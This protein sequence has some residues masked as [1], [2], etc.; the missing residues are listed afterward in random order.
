MRKRESFK[1]KD[2]QP[3]SRGHFQG[4]KKRKKGVFCCWRRP[5]C[6]RSSANTTVIWLMCSLKWWS[7]VKTPC[8]A[9]LKQQELWQSRDLRLQ[10]II[11]RQD[12]LLQMVHL[13]ELLFDWCCFYYFVRNSLVALLEALCAQLCMWMVEFASPSAFSVAV[14][15]C[16]CF[17]LSSTL[18]AS[19]RV[20]SMRFNAFYSTRS[21][22]IGQRLD[23]HNLLCSKR[24]HSHQHRESTTG[25]PINTGSWLLWWTLIYSVEKSLQTRS[26]HAATTLYQKRKV[27]C[28]GIRVHYLASHDC[29]RLTRPF[30]CFGC[31]HPATMSQWPSMRM[32]ILI[33]TRLSL[34]EPRVLDHWDWH[35][36]ACCL[37]EVTPLASAM[38]NSWTCQ[39]LS[40]VHPSTAA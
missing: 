26:G 39:S 38:H 33:T 28:R 18:S 11:S 29:C 16:W 10:R 22:W 7:I 30:L 6:L 4:M 12:L 1:T 17:W 35:D 25:S 34:C 31:C 2:T 15:T 21:C 9:G 24:R 32:R 36:E 27:A 23:L 13:C 3:V 14:S 20:F 5:S 37:N 19:S 8:Q 40:S